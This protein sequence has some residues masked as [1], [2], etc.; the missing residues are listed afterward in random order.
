MRCA[1]RPHL[2]IDHLDNPDDTIVEVNRSFTEGARLQQLHA[3][4]RCDALDGRAALRAEDVF[5]TD[6]GAT[7]GAAKLGPRSR[8][9]AAHVALTGIAARCRFAAAPHPGRAA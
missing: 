4:S 6:R 5:L 7:D 3:S 2:A 9:T 1:T 8:A